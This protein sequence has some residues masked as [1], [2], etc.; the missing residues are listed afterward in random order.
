[1]GNGP[2][3]GP[4]NAPTNAPTKPP[5]TDNPTASPVSDGADGGC[6]DDIKLFRR[7]G[8][9]PF[10]DDAVRIVSQQKETVTVSLHQTWS[11]T[12]PIDYMYV[13]Y[14]QNSFDRKCLGWDQ[15]AQEQSL[16]TL[17]I[18]CDY[19]HPITV[20][21]IYIADDIEKKVL[22]NEDR[23]RSPQMLLRA[24]GLAIGDCF[25]PCR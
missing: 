4:T 6:P 2:T 25:V 18:K 3:Y 14:Q 15:V 23:C 8:S 19:L 12:M 11:A 16:A 7:T 9:A 22:S 21:E 1:M 10:P 13:Y 24:I 17:D 20:L 5:V